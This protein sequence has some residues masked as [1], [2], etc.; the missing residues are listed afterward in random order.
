MP[1]IVEYVMDPEAAHDMFGP[2]SYLQRRAQEEWDEDDMIPGEGLVDV[3]ARDVDCHRQYMH[4]FGTHIVDAYDTPPFVVRQD[5]VDVL[6]DFVTSTDSG[7]AVVVGDHGMGKSHLMAAVGVT[8]ELEAAGC[9]MCPLFVGSSAG[10]RD[11]RLLLRA[12]VRMLLE[13]HSP[14]ALASKDAVP[15]IYMPK[16][17]STTGLF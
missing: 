8:L 15:G 2:D 11:T 12:L 14:E 13:A 10:S 16:Y 17:R 6:V 4:S 7:L 9:V 1:R 5:T 3:N